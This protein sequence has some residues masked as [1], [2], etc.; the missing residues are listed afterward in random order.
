MVLGMIS[1][2]HELAATLTQF[3]C[4]FVSLPRAMA[5][6]EPTKSEALRT[7]NVHGGRKTIMANED[8][9]TRLTI[10]ADANQKPDATN[11]VL[12]SVSSKATDESMRNHWTGGKFLIHPNVPVGEETPK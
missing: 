7:M 6:M 9:L 1:G 4:C 3:G 10:K 2:V 8:D 12:S 5:A 11:A